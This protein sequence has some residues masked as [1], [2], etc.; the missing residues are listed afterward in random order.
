MTETPG[1]TIVLVR[2]GEAAARWGEHADPGLSEKGQEQAEKAST[3]LLDLLDDQVT[4]ISSPMLRA[5]QTA[6]PYAMALG[7]ETKVD[8]AFR[9][10]PTP[11]ELSNRRDWLAQF[12]RQTWSSQS[13]LV[14]SWRDRILLSLVD[15]QAPAVIFTHYMVLNAVV[16]QL[17]GRD[18]TVCFRPDNASITELRRNGKRMRLI[19]LGTEMQTVV[20]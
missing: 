11:A 20:N 19:R 3:T 2:H 14:S 8:E 15:L 5:R 6:Q 18:E 1:D 16:S 12:M 7:I 9:E 17:T 4:V 10:I 13:E